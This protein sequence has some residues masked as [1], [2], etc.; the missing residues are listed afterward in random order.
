MNKRPLLVFSGPVT[1][2]SGYGAHARDIVTALFNLDKYD[3]KIHSINWGNT[4]MN[5]LN[6]NIP[7]HARILDNIVTGLNEQPDIWMQCTVPNEFRTLGKYN[8][9]ITAGIETDSC[10]CEWVEH[11]NKMDLIIVPSEHSKNSLLN[12]VCEKVATNPNMNI[13]NANVKLNKP[14]LVLHEGIDENIYKN[15][16]PDEAPGKAKMRDTLAKIEEKFCFLFVGHWMHGE[17]GEDRKNVSGLVHTFMDTFKDIDTPPALILKTSSGTFSVGDRVKILDKINSIKKMFPDNSK[18]PN[19]YVLHGNLTDIEM[20]CLY[21]HTKVRAFVSFTKGEGYGRPIAE[22]MATGKPVL[23]TNWS[24][25]LDFAKPGGAILLPGEL[26]NV[27]PSTVWKGVIEPESKWFAV[28]Y[29]VAKKEMMKMFKKYDKYRIDAKP[30]AQFMKNNFSFRK[31]QKDLDSYLEQYLPK[32]AKNI[33]FVMPSLSNTNFPALKKHANIT[34][35]LT[36]KIN[37]Q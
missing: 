9:G 34:N 33:P 1:T 6:P 21:N 36:A 32:F 16:V 7:E 3:I 26:R 37:E 8:I 28:D 5:A 25:H 2:V 11:C 10:A 27:H 29:A 15:Y 12:T 20:N 22:F 24:G 13:P 19:V 18:L 14:I 4:P 23:V 17:F 30:S 35:N 31:M